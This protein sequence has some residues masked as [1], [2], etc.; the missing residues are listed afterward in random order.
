MGIFNLYKKTIKSTNVSQNNL[1]RYALNIPNK[2]HI[3][4]IMKSLK[5]LDATTL[6]NSQICILIKLL[7]RHEFIKKI[8]NEMFG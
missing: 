6:Y 8:I 2:T 5:T 1:F 3:T 4:F 7:H